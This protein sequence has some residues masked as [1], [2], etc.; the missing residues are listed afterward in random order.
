M[1]N[2]KTLK[3]VDRK[4]KA[5]TSHSHTQSRFYVWQVRRLGHAVLLFFHLCPMLGINNFFSPLVNNPKH[6]VNLSRSR[7]CPLAGAWGEL[8]H[9]LPHIHTRSCARTLVHM[10]AQW[11]GM[12]VRHAVQSEC[13]F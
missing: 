11:R 13:I 1:Y 6:Q 7:V 12:D 5:N 9:T 8:Q 10:L 2:N 4:K 3:K